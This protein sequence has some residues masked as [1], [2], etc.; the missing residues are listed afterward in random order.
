MT[1]PVFLAVDTFLLLGWDGNR[2]K[3]W[4]TLGKK[5]ILLWQFWWHLKN[6]L[7][8]VGVFFLPSLCWVPS[9][10]LKTK[11]ASLWLLNTFLTEWKG[12]LLQNIPL[13]D[14]ALWLKQFVLPLSVHCNRIQPLHMFILCLTTGPLSMVPRGPFST[15]FTRIYH[16]CKDSWWAN[17]LLIS[18]FFQ[19]SDTVS[20]SFSSDLVYTA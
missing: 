3:V 8:L 6:V 4:V 10:E 19:I 11:W 15:P 5:N 13:N 18:N 17:I 14:T 2:I 9:G 7:T 16:D 20:P 1:G 12:V